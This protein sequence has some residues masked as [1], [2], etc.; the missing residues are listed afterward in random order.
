MRVVQGIGAAFLMAN[1]SAILTDAFPAEQRGLALGHQHGGGD[2]RLVHRPGAGRRPGPDLVAA[3][4]PGLGS[5]R[6]VRHR[7]GLPEARGPR[8]FA[9]PA[10][11]DW[12]G[13]ITFGVGLIALLV[14]ITYGILPYGGHT[15][16]WTAPG[17]IARARSAGSCSLTAFV[18]HRAA[19][20]GADVPPAL[21]RIRAF[22]GGTVATLPRGALSRGGLMFMLILW[23]QGIW[24]P[25]HGYSFS[26]TPLWAG[27]Y[28][29]PL[30]VGFLIAGPIAGAPVGPLRGAA[31]H[32]RRHDPVGAR[33]RCCST[34]CRSTSPTGVRAG[35]LPHRLRDGPVRRAQPDRD[36]EQPAARPTRRG[37]RHGGDLPELGAPCSRSGLL[38]PD[39][40]RPVLHPAGRAA[41]RTVVAR[42][43]ACLRGRG[44]APAAGRQPVRGVPR[45]QPDAAPCWRRRSPPPA[46]DGGLPH[47]PPVLP[48]LWSRTRSRPG[49]T[50]RSTS[51]PA[52]ARWR[53][54]PRGCAAASTTTPRPPSPSRSA[55]NS[56]WPSRARMTGSRA[57]RRPA[58]RAREPG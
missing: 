51:R 12:L 13:N 23:L 45:L 36:H 37:R 19:R 5:V 56:R 53:R 3:G 39:H 8:R 7:L 10:K 41:A 58:A 38:Q 6:P 17:V 11:I 16:G 54:S 32:H 25:L 49:S 44:L 34:R 31:V 29:L 26:D 42:R 1:S 9:S 28:M 14:G 47:R 50:R 22:S 52:A 21:F 30:S 15:M 33:L 4:V 40:R 57:G 43:A 48:Q 2:R 27:I 20:R 18:V 24:L 55:P 35:D 46:R